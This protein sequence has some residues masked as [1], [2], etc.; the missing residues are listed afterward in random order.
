M[1]HFVIWTDIDEL[2]PNAELKHMFIE[3]KLVYRL[4][5]NMC[6]FDADETESLR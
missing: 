5:E 3:T 1:L 2:Q 6:R 4:A